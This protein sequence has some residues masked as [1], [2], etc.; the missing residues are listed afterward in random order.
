MA[1]KTV[2][3]VMVA[4]GD[5]VIQFSDNFSGNLTVSFKKTTIKKVLFWT[6][7]VLQGA[8]FLRPYRQSAHAHNMLLSKRNQ[9][10]PRFLPLA[11]PPEWPDNRL[12]I[13]TP[14]STSTSI[15][16]NVG[17]L[18]QRTKGVAPAL[19]STFPVST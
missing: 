15:A 6:R 11:Y 13:G 19:G 8:G 18:P 17:V 9:C 14:A 12:P 3:Y 10:N 1:L 7:V 4:K 2:S 5:Y 16:I